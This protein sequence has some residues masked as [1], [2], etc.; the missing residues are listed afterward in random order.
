YLEEHGSPEWAELVR[1]WAELRGA[2]ARRRAPREV[3][4][5]NADL[6]SRS[7]VEPWRRLGFTK[8]SNGLPCPISIDVEVFLQQASAFVPFLNAGLVDRLTEVR[9]HIEAFTV[10][11]QLASLDA[12]DLSE[13]FLGDDGV[14]LLCQS[15]Y[16]KKLQRLNLASNAIGPAGVQD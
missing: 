9:E 14:R 10:C 11:P 12:L 13:N 1:A 5:L 8:W 6:M 4:Q 16:L 3:V 15:P 2:G 7:W